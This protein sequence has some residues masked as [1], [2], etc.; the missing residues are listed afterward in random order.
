ME[1]FGLAFKAYTHHQ[2]NGKQKLVIDTYLK[3]QKSLEHEQPS[4]R[5]KENYGRL[6]TF[7][8]E[9]LE[10]QQATTLVFGYAN[11]FEKYGFQTVDMEF[12][13]VAVV[14]N[15]VNEQRDQ[16]ISFGVACLITDYPRTSSETKLSNKNEEQKK[17]AK[18][19]FVDTIRA[20][21][22]K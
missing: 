3:P 1:Q 9:N 7:F 21:V 8:E 14:L 5:N 22:D 18:G 4:T 17:L 2:S 19:L 12:G 15:Q 20:F 6:L 10:F 13:Y 11:A 16:P